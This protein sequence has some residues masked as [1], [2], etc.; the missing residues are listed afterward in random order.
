MAKRKTDYIRQNSK[1][2]K[3]YK[4]SIGSIGE[5]RVVIHKEF[6]STIEAQIWF[7]DYLVMAKR[8]MEERNRGN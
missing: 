4:F 2:P 3:L 5:S 6:D 8:K 7:E 1:N